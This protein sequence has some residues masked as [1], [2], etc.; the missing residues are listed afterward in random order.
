MVAFKNADF[1]SD[2]SIY[3]PFEETL[4]LALDPSKKNIKYLIVFNENQDI[5]GGCMGVNTVRETA[6]GDC[7]WF[8]I[9][10]NL[11]KSLRVK[12]S[13]E[14]VQ[15]ILDLM[16]KKGFERIVT[17]MGTKSGVRFFE[18]HGFVNAPTEVEENNWVYVL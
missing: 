9:H 15:C 18:K 10:P 17:K 13:N 7:G 6:D 11:D 8:F 16:R 12:I 2:F 1:N 5:I 3:S 14:L 4:K